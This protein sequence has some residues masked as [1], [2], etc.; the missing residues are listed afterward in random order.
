MWIKNQND[1]LINL[2][3]VDRVK[4]EDNILYAYSSGNKI[5]I[6]KYNNGYQAYKAIQI[7]EKNIKNETF[8]MDYPKM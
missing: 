5:L 2:D 4:R 3:N 6:A 7:V 1:V 8:M